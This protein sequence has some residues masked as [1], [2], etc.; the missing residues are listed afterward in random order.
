MTSI[1]SVGRERRQDPRQPSREHRLAGS[2]RAGEQEVVSTRRPRS[3]ARAALAPVLSHRRGR[4]ATPAA[5]ARSA[6]PRAPGRARRAGTRPHRRGAAREPA[7]SPRAPPRATSARRRASAASPPRRAA[8][9]SAERLRRPAAVARRERARRRPRAPPATLRGICPDAARIE[10]AIGRSKPEPSFRSAAGARLTVIRRE[11]PLQLGRGDPAPDAVLRLL[12]RAVREAHDREPGHAVL[13][14]RL[15][16]DATGLESDERVR[17]GARE[18]PLH[19]RRQSSRVCARSCAESGN[20]R[21]AAPRRRE[22]PRRHRGRCD[23]RVHAGARQATSRTRPRPPQATTG[24]PGRRSRGSRP[25]RSTLFAQQT[26][27]HRRSRSTRSAHAGVHRR[28]RRGRMLVYQLLRGR[29]SASAP[30]CG[31]T[32]SRPVTQLPMPAGV[33]SPNVGVLARRSRPAGSCT[34][35]ARRTAAA[36]QLILL[37]NLTTGEQ[38]VLDA[39]HDRRGLNERGAAERDLRRRRRC[40]PVS[41]V[42]DLPLRPRRAPPR[43][44]C[45]RRRASC[46]YAPSV[47]EYGT[48]YYVQSGRGSW[49]VGPA[50]EAARSTAARR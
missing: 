9:A 27:P 21:L 40:R 38:R 8:S 18:H 4:E 34:A 49:T 44:R 31:C 42:R 19:A 12:A 17:E 20:S 29:D 15:D 6:A 30:I 28:D 48:V 10:S 2:R 50:R 16:L 24:S 25:T 7:R 14:V 3:R 37:R 47:N 11:R 45:P 22:P 32:T 33:N 36:C 39:I 35:A 43:R 1:A 26:R 23:R 5:G 13:E 41:E 46:V